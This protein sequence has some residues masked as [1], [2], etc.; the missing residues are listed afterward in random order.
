M[1]ERPFL[2]FIFKENKF[3]QFYIVGMFMCVCVPVWV[4]VLAHRI[5]FT[6]N[7]LCFINIFIINIVGWCVLFAPHAYRPRLFSL[8]RGSV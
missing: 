5:V 2:Y 4:C 6:E 7:I 8:T 3:D 1:H